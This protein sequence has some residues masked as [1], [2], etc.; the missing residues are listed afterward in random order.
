[1]NQWRQSKFIL[2]GGQSPKPEGSRA[3]VGFLGGGSEPA[4]HQLQV[5]GAF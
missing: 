2:R 4:P 5:W 1:V 3:G